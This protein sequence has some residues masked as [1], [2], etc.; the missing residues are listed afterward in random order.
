VDTLW[1]KLQQNEFSGEISKLLSL[2]P[3]VVFTS[4]WGGDFVSFINQGRARGVFDQMTILFNN[5]G[6]NIE[7]FGKD[8]PDGIIV[9]FRGP[10]WIEY[11]DPKENP[12]QKEFIDLYRAKYGKCPMPPRKLPRGSGPAGGKSGL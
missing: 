10:H 3:E 8:L 4:F 2:R 7:E 5:D 11:P 12:L 9:G 1:P 6:A